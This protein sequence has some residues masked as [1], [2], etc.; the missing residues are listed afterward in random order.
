MEPPTA[1][2]SP[3]DV[4]QRTLAETKLPK[5]LIALVSCSD[6]LATAVKAGIALTEMD[7]EGRVAK[8]A[9]RGIVSV[10][11]GDI[12]LSALICNGAC[13]FTLFT[14][15]VVTPSSLS[16]KGDWQYVEKTFHVRMPYALRKK[17]RQKPN[18]ACVRFNIAER[19]FTSMTA[20]YAWMLANDAT[21]LMAAALD[22]DD[23]KESTT[24]SEEDVIAALK[25]AKI[26]PEFVE[27]ALKHDL[28]LPVPVF[29]DDAVYEDEE[30]LV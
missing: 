14:D 26:T 8:L 1:A 10:F 16:V 30:S 27:L 15:I 2:L 19:R 28:P 18:T 22:A 20:H 11:T 12:L 6:S 13:D 25:S 4:I 7:S 21:Q 23:Q 29:D 17:L 9:R 5:A 24:V 3:A